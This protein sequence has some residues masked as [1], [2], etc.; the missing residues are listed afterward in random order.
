MQRGY[1]QYVTDVQKRSL[2][3]YV[4]V[5]RLERKAPRR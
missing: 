2:Y 4:V 3:A 1:Y 5:P